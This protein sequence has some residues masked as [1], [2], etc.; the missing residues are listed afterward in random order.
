MLLLEDLANS[1]YHPGRP[2]IAR[3]L[4]WLASFHARFLDAKPP[5]LWEQGTY[6]HLGTRREEW[7]R[8]E[9]GPF[10]DAAFELDRQLREVR[11]RTLVHGDAK[12]SNFLWSAQGAAA[13][14]FQYVGEGCGIRDVAYF[15]DCCLGEEQDE[16]WLDFYFSLLDKPQV[17]AEWRPLFPVAWADFCRFEQGWRGPTPLGRFSW[18]QLEMALAR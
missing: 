5:E 1:G 7:E 9:P 13:V 3:G 10:K 11:Y 15:L 12:P 18:R 14:D 16:R 6:W 4:R 17:E 2:D 8:M